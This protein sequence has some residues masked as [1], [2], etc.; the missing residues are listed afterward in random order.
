MTDGDV[1]ARFVIPGSAI[2]KVF[3]ELD[4]DGIPRAE[5]SDR[6]SSELAGTGQAESRGEGDSE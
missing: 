5:P 4:R 2:P 3:I 6:G 1:S